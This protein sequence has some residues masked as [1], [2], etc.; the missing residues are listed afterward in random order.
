MA[1]ARLYSAAGES[2]GELD[3]PEAVFGGPVKE[4][5]MHQAVVAYLANQRRGTASSLGRSGVSYSTSKLYRQKGTGRSR[6]GSARSGTRRGGGAIFGPQPRSYRM[7]LPR[8]VRR[9]ATRSA[10]ADKGEAGAVR[11]LEGLEFDRPKTR[12]FVEL[13]RSLELENRRVLLV[14]DGPD[15]IVEKSARN[16]PGVDV[17]SWRELNAYRILR[18]EALVITRPALEKMAEGEAA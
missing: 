7:S 5:V 4:H 13:L 14:L 2:R 1:K 17:I 8:K 15:E 18:A 16:I 6:A 12:R 3:L 11:V 10:L 9:V